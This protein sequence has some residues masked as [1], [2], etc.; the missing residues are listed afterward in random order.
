MRYIVVL[1]VMLVLQACIQNSGSEERKDSESVQLTQVKDTLYLKDTIY[2]VDSVVHEWGKLP[3][4]SGT[5]LKQSSN[6]VYSEWEYFK[7]YLGA[8]E[9]SAVL[10]NFEGTN[11]PCSW[12][13]SFKTGIIYTHE[14]CMEVGAN[15]SI[16]FPNYQKEELLKYIDWF[17]K[18]EDNVWNKEHT[19]YTPKEEGAGCYLEIKK[20]KEG[21]YVLEY[22]CGC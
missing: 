8:I 21:N 14:E 7:Q 6:N 9:D 1:Y 4:P 13:Q 20:N 11:E 12:S 19:Q 15:V 10:K 17:H 18:T 2:I 16:T 5:F 3:K 22:Y